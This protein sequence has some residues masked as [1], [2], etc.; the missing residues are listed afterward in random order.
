M[1]KAYLI[2]DDGTK[3][4]GLTFGADIK[5]VDKSNKVE[6]VFFT[7]MTGF[8]E[9]LTDPKYRGKIV[10]STFPIAGSAGVNDEDVISNDPNDSPV[11]YIVREYCDKPSNFRARGTIDE[12]MKKRGIVGLYGI[13]T[14]RL[15]RILRDKGHT[16]G[17]ISEI[18]E[19]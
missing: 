18:C 6:T 12:F 5:T 11:G 13:D 4:E 9:M 17:F 19:N 10:V 15:T 2:L 1:S 16:K 14:R 3:F 8:Q 7:G